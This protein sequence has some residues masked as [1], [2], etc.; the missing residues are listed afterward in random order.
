MPDEK[1]H[2]KEPRAADSSAPEDPVDAGDREP[3]DEEAV[4]RWRR[5]AR[6]FT[7]RR[8]LAEDTRDLLAAFLST[9][10]KAKSELVRMT[11]R[12]V[13]NYLD[14]L[15]LKEDLL[16]IATNYRL[17]VRASFHLEPIAEALRDEPGATDE[18]HAD[19]DDAGRE[20]K[21]PPNR[22]EED[23]D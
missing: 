9:S 6:R 10:D 20:T 12:E 3:V 18:P 16:D 17:E 19:S 14:G 13:R 21:T 15:Q 4:S 23:E 2:S 5:L 22:T 1:D 8:E 7:D 11:G